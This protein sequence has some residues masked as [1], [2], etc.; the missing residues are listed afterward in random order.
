M[1][2]PVRV[3]LCGILSIA[4]LFPISFLYSILLSPSSIFDHQLYGFSIGTLSAI[5][6]LVCSRICGVDE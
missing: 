2:Y 3:I 6:I 5:T 4:I 1:Y